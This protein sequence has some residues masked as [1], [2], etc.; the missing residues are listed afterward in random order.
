MERFRTERN[1]RD[2]ES[3]LKYEKEIIEIKSLLPGTDFNDEGI[4]VTRAVEEYM[5]ARQ[6]VSDLKERKDEIIEKILTSLN[7]PKR[8]RGA[9]KQNIEAKIWERATTADSM[10]IHG[11]A[12]TGKS[13][14]AAALIGEQVRGFTPIIIAGHTPGY[15]PH[16]RVIKFDT[17]E[18][19]SF[20]SVP[21]LLLNIRS[22]FQKDSEAT[23]EG[24]IDNLSTDRPQI[25]DDLGVEKT[26]EWSLQTLYTIIDRRY[27][28]EQR[29]IFTSNLSLGD[30]G[31]KLGDRIASRIAG[32]CRVIELKGKDRRIGRPL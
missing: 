21:D 8:L 9:R 29:T 24:V 32:M 12:G 16:F 1:I 31:V 14:L 15:N 3:R 17:R 20:I 18:A 6:E 23:E 26:S 30:I 5:S 11:P 22:T 25:F 19:P 4:D 27:R 13:Y 28:E 2:S 10:F 7:V